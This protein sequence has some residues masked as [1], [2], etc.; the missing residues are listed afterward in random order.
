M[1]TPLGRNGGVR[2]AHRFQPALHTQAAGADHHRAL[3]LLQP[4]DRVAQGFV[5][6]GPAA[7]RWLSA[8]VQFLGVAERVQSLLRHRRA[9]DFVLRPVAL[10]LYD[11]HW[12]V[13]VAQVADIVHPVGQRTI[14]EP[15]A[16]VLVR[17]GVVAVLGPEQQE[18][19]ARLNEQRMRAMVDV[20][21]A[22][23]PDM[24]PRGPIAVRRRQGCCGHQNAVRRIPLRLKRLA[25]QS[26]AELRLPSAPI[27]DDQQLDVREGLRAGIE[28]AQMGTQRR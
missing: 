6:R 23:V 28:I 22:E 9:A 26:A 20:L 27:A 17:I 25:A 14:A 15:D 13:G 19:R 1:L 18:H 2:V 7:F 10:R 12:A 16:N 4:V 21:T 24:Q 11:E 8:V 3:A 5:Q